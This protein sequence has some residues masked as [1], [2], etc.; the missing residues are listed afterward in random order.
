[1]KYK[2]FLDTNVVVD[3]LGEREPFYESIAK[4]ATL[5]DKGSIQLTVSALTYS[6][7]YYLLSRFEDKEVVKEK[8]RK[9]KI[10]AKTSDL[11]DKVISKGLDSKFKDFEDSLQ[12]Y[13]AI[14]AECNVLVTR[15]WR[16]FKESDIPVLTPDE[17]LASLQNK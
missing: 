3:L 5:A 14:N 8:I 4:I 17:F 6:T 10:I 15:N 2:L 9:F 1:M 12:Y 7:V 13:C 11:T 16:D